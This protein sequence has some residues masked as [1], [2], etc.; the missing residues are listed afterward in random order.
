MRKLR[1]AMG[2]FSAYFPMSTRMHFIGADVVM[3][4]MSSCLCSLF[5]CSMCLLIIC[6]SYLLEDRSGLNAHLH[7]FLYG[8]EERYVFLSVPRRAYDNAVASHPGHHIT[9]FT[10]GQVAQKVVTSAL[11]FWLMDG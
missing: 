2:A 4:S 6:L 5:Y 10:P 8:E 11:V 3:E 1:R 7:T 9:L